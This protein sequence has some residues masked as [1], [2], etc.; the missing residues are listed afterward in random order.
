MLNERKLILL[1]VCFRA[2]RV[3]RIHQTDR[4]T[5]HLYLSGFLAQKIATFEIAVAILAQNHVRCGDGKHVALKLEAM[6]L[7]LLDVLLLRIRISHHQHSVHGRNQKSC[8]SAR[9]VEH[10]IVRLN[11]HQ[12]AHQ[13]A[14]VTGRQNDAE[15]LSIAA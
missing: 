11:I 1:G 8:R 9:R 12:L 15:R 7:L 13:I 6:K 10:G 3:G 14:D 2:L 5:L 4:C